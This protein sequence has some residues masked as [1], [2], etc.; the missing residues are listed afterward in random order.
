MNDIIGFAISILLVVALV[1]LYAFGMY[2]NKKTPL[3]EQ[4]ELP[5]IKCKHC[6]SSSCSYSETNREN[7]R[8]EG[9]R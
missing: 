1:A 2:L 3:P 5:S 6:S 7:S 8:E 9:E 4:F